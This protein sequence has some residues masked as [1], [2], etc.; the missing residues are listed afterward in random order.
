MN[1]S[2]DY[3]WRA[4]MKWSRYFLHLKSIFCIGFGLIFLSGCGILYTNSHVPRSYR[5]ASPSDVQAKNTDPMGS[6]QACNY[7]LLFLFAWGN[8]GYA[9][10]TRKALQQH[11]Q[12][13]L[14]DV[15]A[16]T[17]V[18]SFLGLYSEF[19]TIVT[20]KMAEPK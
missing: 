3:S 13:L 2:M 14:Y 8:G 12:A 5:S 9:S 4:P 19:C 15:K 11:P 20:G 16:D 18:K 1:S 10:A 6:G 7:S 17:K